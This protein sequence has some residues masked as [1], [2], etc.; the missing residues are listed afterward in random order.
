M[1]ISLFCYTSRECD[2]VEQLLNDVVAALDLVKSRA[3]LVYSATGVRDLNKEVS[4]AFSFDAKA[5]FLLA[6]NDKACAASLGTMAEA[7]KQIFGP[8]EILIL[9]EN[10]TRY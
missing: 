8:N 5:V 4:L 9:F 2:E 3:Y 1:A 7:L 10:E 6:L